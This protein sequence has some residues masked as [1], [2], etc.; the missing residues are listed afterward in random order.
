MARPFDPRETG[1]TKD[2]KENARLLRALAVAGF[3]AGNV[4]LLSVSVWSGAEGATRDLFH[5]LSAMIALP[6]VAYAG[7]PFFYSAVNALRHGRVNMDV[8][9]SLGV[10]LASLHEP[11]RDHQ[12]RRARLFRCLRHAAVLPAR[13]PLPRPHDA[14]PRPLGHRAA[15][16]ALRRGRH[17]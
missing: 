4:M 7:R 2:D 15:G 3:A 9:I 10:L 5:W 13:R 12:R 11:V 16:L 14:R 1:L 8:P 6:A 17:A